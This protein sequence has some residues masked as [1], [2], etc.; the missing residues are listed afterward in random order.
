MIPLI[1]PRSSCERLL[2]KWRVASI[3]RRRALVAAVMR[4]T[5]SGGGASELSPGE[6]PTSA[7]TLATKRSSRL[8]NS[9]A[10]LLLAA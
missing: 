1:D 7:A 9:A 5:S 4:S 8:V 3:S 10:R 6:R 2:R